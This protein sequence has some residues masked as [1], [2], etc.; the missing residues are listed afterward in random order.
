[1]DLADDLLWK[2]SE[3]THIFRFARVSSTYIDKYISSQFDK[4]NSDGNSNSNYRIKGTWDNAV[5]HVSYNVV[6]NF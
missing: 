1:M 6:I 4:P 5:Q 2:G 3:G